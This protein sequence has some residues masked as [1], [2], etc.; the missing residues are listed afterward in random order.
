MKNYVP[1]VISAGGSLGEATDHILSTKLLRKVRNRHDN[2]PEDL[3]A[4]MDS[5][6]EAWDG[7]DKK[8]QPDR[9]LAVVSDELRR[10]GHYEEEAV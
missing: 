7:L 8:N 5:I 4:L 3:I 6:Q 1:V 10:L 9:S 2:R